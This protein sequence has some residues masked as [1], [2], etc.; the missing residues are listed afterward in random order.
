MTE[1]FWNFT[2]TNLLY[3]LAAV[4][5]LLFIGVAIVGLLLLIKYFITDLW[6]E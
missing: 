2:L 1:E 5:I 6:E 3:T 4:F